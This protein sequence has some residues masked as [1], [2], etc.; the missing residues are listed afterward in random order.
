MKKIFALMIAV[1]FVFCVAGSAVAN[2]GNDTNPGPG[3]YVKIH[4]ATAGTINYFPNGHPDPQD[5]NEWQYIGPT[6][7][8]QT[9]YTKA[10]AAPCYYNDGGVWGNGEGGWY[11]FSN[12]GIEVNAYAQGTK[13]AWAEAFATGTAW[14]KGYSL[15]IET[16]HFGFGSSGAISGINLFGI[17]AGLGV[18]NCSFFFNPDYAFVA[19]KYD[20]L[21]SQGNWVQIDNGEGG[22]GAYAGNSTSVFFKG[23]SFEDDFGA[24]VL[25]CRRPI[26]IDMGIPAFEVNADGASAIAGGFSKVCYVDFT[27]YAAAS[28]LTVGFSGYCGDKGAVW[29]SGEAGHQAVVNS[30]GNFGLSAGDATFSYGGNGNF[31]AGMAQTSGWTAITYGCNS[32]TVTS[33]STA[34]SKA[35]VN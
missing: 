5:K 11:V 20:G 12:G 24:I 35:G 25:G 31:G 4:G 29:G 1:L 13:S 16:P 19:I 18:D 21:V 28:A 30:N 14:G 33:Y 3:Y 2:N 8:F 17:G 7:N 32:S 23:G 10:I 22:T 26:V 6:L 15:A 27:N 34:F 9:A